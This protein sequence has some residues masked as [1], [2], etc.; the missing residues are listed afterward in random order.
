MRTWK[1]VDIPGRELKRS[2]KTEMDGSHLFVAYTLVGVT[3]F[4]DDDV[5]GV[6]QLQNSQKLI[7]EVKRMIF[8]CHFS[9][10]KKF[11]KFS[12]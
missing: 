6:F 10:E 1:E 7:L 5:Y 4:D 11:Y 2:P 12:R 9:I 8:T 3:G